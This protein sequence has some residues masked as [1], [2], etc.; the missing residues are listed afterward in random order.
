MMHLFQ[1]QTHFSAL[2]LALLC[3]ALSFE[4]EA[5]TT[6]TDK[7]NRIELDVTA[8]NATAFLVTFAELTQSAVIVDGYL[9]DRRI[10]LAGTYHDAASV[11]KVAA[12]QLGVSL[13][14]EQ[15]VYILSHPCTPKA[16]ATLPSDAA[17]EKPVS[18]HFQSLDQPAATIADIAMS[19][20]E[21]MAQRQAE[22]HTTTSL[23]SRHIFG[24]I[25]VH[26]R[27]VGHKKAME[28]IS[29]ASGYRLTQ[30]TDQQFELHLLPRISNCA[31]ALEPLIKNVETPV[32]VSA[33][34]EGR[35]EYLEHFRIEQMRFTGRITVG[36][37]TSLVI[38]LD[39][40]KAA[41]AQLGS[42]V[43]KQNGR[44]THISASG[45]KIREILMDADESWY[46]RTRTVPYR[47][48]IDD[49]R[50]PPVPSAMAAQFRVDAR[51]QLQ[52]D[53]FA[54]AVQSTSKAI[55]LDP[56]N[57]LGY[58]WRAWARSKQ[59]DDDGAIKDANR[60]IAL[61][62]TASYL[63]ALRA[64]VKHAAGQTQ[65]ANADWLKAIKLETDPEYRETLK[66]RYADFL[67]SKAD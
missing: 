37:V 62:K 19:A 45:V 21:P 56:N 26:L 66:R 29:Y 12:E 43:G 13:H 35:K 4:I 65:S 61:N 57:V 15:G 6:S 64:D 33:D 32:P 25:G 63:Y 22:A 50:V 1:R 60:A 31:D 8:T 18:L 59:K 10:D 36:G 49:S 51:L 67:K 46:E 44:V 55:A 23:N 7:K 39:N 48:A 47:V 11:F 16:R 40:G 53:E 14:F 54:Q 17:P 42:K 20:G 27:N 2:A 5:R 38:Q 9:A 3:F 58:V 52:R 28:L 41:R 24:A 30:N 34:G